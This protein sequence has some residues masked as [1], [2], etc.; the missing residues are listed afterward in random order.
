MNKFNDDEREVIR[1]IHN[2]TTLSEAQIEEVFRGLAFSNASKYL[3]NKLLVVPL[4]GSFKAKLSNKRL[5][6]SG[7]VYDTSLFSQASPFFKKELGLLATEIEEETTTQ[8]LSFRWV[9]GRM[10]SALERN[11]NYEES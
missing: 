8:S 7:N 6:P 5:T 4:L 1:T 11:I 2:V 10:A 3:D 9:V